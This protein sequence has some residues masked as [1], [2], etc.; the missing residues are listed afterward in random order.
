MAVPGAVVAEG[1]VTSLA[2]LAFHSAVSHHGD[3]DCC[4]CQFAVIQAELFCLG[5]CYF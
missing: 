4:L 1:D 5:S 2:V 3:T